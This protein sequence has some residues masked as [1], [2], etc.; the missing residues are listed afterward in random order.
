MPLS[1]NKRLQKE[2]KVAVNPEKPRLLT[3]A[4]A[5]TAMAALYDKYKTNG[6]ADIKAEKFE[7]AVRWWV[8]PSCRSKPLMSTTVRT[9]ALQVHR[10]AE[11]RLVC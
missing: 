3:L 10:G 11:A 6:N 1:R 5:F 8:V 2:P 4:L 7:S 9:S